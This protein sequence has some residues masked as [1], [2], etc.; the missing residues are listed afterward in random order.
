MTLEFI[1][2]DAVA[3]ASQGENTSACGK[4]R[5]RCPDFW[6]AA[7]SF[8][9]LVFNR[10]AHYR[11]DAEVLRQTRHFAQRLQ[12]TLA[13]G[14][15]RTPGQVVFWRTTQPGHENCTGIQ[16]PLNDAEVSAVDSG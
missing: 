5:R 16:R 6:R 10:G 7:R 14:R 9:V 3:E 2:N 4:L 8:D 12:E 1:R 13:A 15:T 11:P